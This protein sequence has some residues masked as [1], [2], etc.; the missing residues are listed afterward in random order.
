MRGGWEG[1]QGKQVSY[2]NGDTITETGSQRGTGLEGEGNELSLG[3]ILLELPERYLR[4][5]PAPWK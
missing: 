4:I 3:Y 2:L 5:R 1:V